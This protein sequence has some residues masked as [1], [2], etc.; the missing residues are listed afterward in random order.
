[1][2]LLLEGLFTFAT[3]EHPKHMKPFVM[4]LQDGSG[5]EQVPTLFTPFGGYNN[6]ENKTDGTHI[7]H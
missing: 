1:M 2:L 3:Y 7:N 4:L 5:S 6:I